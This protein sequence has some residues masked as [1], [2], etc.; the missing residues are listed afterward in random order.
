MPVTN[1][2]NVMIKISLFEI[3]IICGS[4]YKNITEFIVFKYQSI[5]GSKQAIVTVGNAK[6]SA[7]HILL[8]Y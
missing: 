6:F 5:I 3:E 8:I 2:I 1:N 7:F 4:P